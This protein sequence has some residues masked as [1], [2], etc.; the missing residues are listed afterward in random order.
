MWCQTL[1]SLA[2]WTISVDRFFTQLLSIC[3]LLPATYNCIF[4]KL[5]PLRW[6]SPCPH[7][8][9]QAHCQ[10]RNTPI[11]SCGTVRAYSL[12]ELKKSFTAET[13]CLK[14]RI[15]FCFL[16][17]LFYCRR[18]LHSFETSE[19]AMPIGK[20]SLLFEKSVRK[21]ELLHL[22]YLDKKD[23]WAQGFSGGI[24]GVQL[25]LFSRFASWFRPVCIWAVTW[26]VLYV[27]A[28]TIAVQRFRV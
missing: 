17:F 21:A 11:W 16:I 15:K 19:I 7:F 23:A 4:D 18:I 27:K 6:A 9:K 12:K 25:S 28:K 2:E 10:L 22:S 26:A 20:K 5:F 14:S 8:P 24:S 1:I 3:S 13:L